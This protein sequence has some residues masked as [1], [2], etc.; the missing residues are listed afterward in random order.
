MPFNN[1]QESIIKKKD[2][3]DGPNASVS[4]ECVRDAMRELKGCEFQLYMLLSMNK[5]GFKMDFNAKWLE[6][7]FGTTRK[8]WSKAK[9]T[10]KQKG[11][12][13]QLDEEGTV[14]EFVERP[15]SV[16]ER[17]GF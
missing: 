12:L 3:I 6:D 8:T 15:E 1:E 2:I 4:V 5:V 10:L 7:T 14:Y 13:R 16:M 11:Y 17:W 9:D